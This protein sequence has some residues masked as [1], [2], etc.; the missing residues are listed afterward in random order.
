VTATG[1]T[2]TLKFSAANPPFEW[3]L[4]NVSLVLPALTSETVV[5]SGTPTEGQTLTANVTDNDPNATINYQWQYENGSTWTNIAGATASTFTVGVAQEGEMLRAVATAADATTL[6]ANS[7]ATAAVKATAPVLTIANNA[8]TVTAG[9]GV[10]M[11]VSVTVPQAGDMVNVYIAG[12]PSYETI[13]DA[14]DGMTFAGS[15]VTL[16]AAEVDSGLTLNSSYTGTGHPVAAL[17]LTAT[18]GASSAALTTTASQTLSVTD[19]PRPTVS[20]AI[21]T[22]AFEL[23]IQHASAGF[24]NLSGHGGGPNWEPTWSLAAHASP[25]ASTLSHA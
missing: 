19:P 8:P 21:D 6:S 1:P 3:D 24:N 23:L 10:A 13:V 5:I 16:T 17:T 18:N 7:S 25:S 22:A 20:D 15:S 12:L 9:G 2:S 14:L 11:G 4:D